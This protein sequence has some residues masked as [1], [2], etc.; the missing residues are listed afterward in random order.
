M[1]PITVRIATLK[2]VS[3]PRV[4]ICRGLG[5]CVG[6]ALWESKSNIGGLA[7]ILLPSEEFSLKKDDPGKFANQAIELMLQ[8]MKDLG[9]IKRY[10]VAKIA[11]GARMFASI[12]PQS[13]RV[14]V[15]QRNV[16]AVKDKLAELKIPIV[17]EDCGGTHGRT[18]EFDTKTGR[19]AIYLAD[20]TK[21]VL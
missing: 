16:I 8:K 5:S 15:G 17:A 3:N 19:I 7:H 21:K 11:G 2:V 18:M 12:N 10:I 14:H 20:K 6:V 1:D 13:E 9:A 4:L